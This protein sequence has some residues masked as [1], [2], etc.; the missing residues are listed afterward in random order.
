[1]IGASICTDHALASAPCAYN[2]ASAGLALVP[3]LCSLAKPRGGAALQI[4]IGSCAGVS[5]PTR[6]HHG[7]QNVG[8]LVT[9]GYPEMVLIGV[10]SPLPA[11]VPGSCGRVRQKFATAGNPS[12][13]PV[14]SSMG[15]DTES[16]RPVAKSGLVAQ[17]RDYCLDVP[18]AGIGANHL[19]AAILVEANLTVPEF[20][21]QYHRHG[22]VGSRTP[23]TGLGLR[24]G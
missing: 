19:H 15:N 21:E 12:G 23:G 8:L 20:V 3:R 22:F 6:S 2:T 11:Y 1:M 14:T 17:S 10:G 18:L 16:S 7:C 13:Q 9:A 4:K 5:G 24:P